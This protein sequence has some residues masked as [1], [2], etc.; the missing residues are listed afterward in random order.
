[1][2]RNILTSAVLGSGTA[3]PAAVT[4]HLVAASSPLHSQ[5]RDPP[6]NV[7]QHYAEKVVSFSPCGIGGIVPIREHIKLA[8]RAAYL[9]GLDHLVAELSLCLKILERTAPPLAPL[10]G[11]GT[12]G[13]SSKLAVAASFGP[14]REA[15]LMVL[16][17]HG[18]WGVWNQT[19]VEEDITYERNAATGLFE[20]QA[21]L[22]LGSTNPFLQSMSEMQKP[23]LSPLEEFPVGTKVCR[24]FGIYGKFIGRVQEFK[25]PY[26][27]IQYPDGDREEISV[28]QMR[29]ARMFSA[30]V[31]KDEIVAW[32]QRHRSAPIQK[33]PAGQ[34]QPP[35][36]TSEEGGF[37]NIKV[38]AAQDAFT[39]VAS[40]LVPPSHRELEADRPA[41]ET[42]VGKTFFLSVKF[43]DYKICCKSDFDALGRPRKK[44]R[45]GGVKNRPTEGEGLFSSKH[46]LAMQMALEDDAQP[47]QG[48]GGGA[49]G[50]SA[51][52]DSN[53][54]PPVSTMLPGAVQ[55]RGWETRKKRLKEA[56]GA[57]S[58]NPEKEGSVL[59]K[60]DQTILARLLAIRAVKEA[61]PVA[62]PSPSP[63]SSPSETKP[64]SKPK[65]KS[66]AK[67]TVEPK[68]QPP[69]VPSPSP[70]KASPK[71]KKGAEEAKSFPLQASSKSK[72]GAEKIKPSPV[73]SPS[74]SKK[75]TKKAKSFPVQSSPESKK[76]PE[77]MKLKLK[78]KVTK[79][80]A[81]TVKEE[82][83][84]T[85][86]ARSPAVK[87]KRPNPDNSGKS[88]AAVMPGHPACRQC[89]ANASGNSSSYKKG[90]EDFCPRS[91]TF[92]ERQQKISKKRAVT[93]K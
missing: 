64:K 57:G 45:G 22:K 14:I 88:A 40:K 39:G 19:V 13:G 73:Q 44:Q 84:N 65:S 33:A 48:A 2:Y 30:V 35:T 27:R 17:I 61:E 74:K 1:L 51:N 25:F 87:R 83:S 41:A 38:H 12:G 49:S 78:S 8:M 54:P 58:L 11:A 43:G 70:V 23:K 90:H 62:S 79:T 76:S 71:L 69:T 7:W 59:P 32:E 6:S 5:K 67:S 72:K 63:L 77:K 91:K 28:S 66:K 37:K 82:M 93:K 3:L 34:V 60:G 80:A 68:S 50:T 52:L 56:A 4:K 92:Q 85:D 16:E 53:S 10:G 46:D 20:A 26:F 36:I 89:T 15:V 42:F 86:R 81:I 24:T 21:K 29:D 47:H 55:K 9:E 75:G 31:K 18:G